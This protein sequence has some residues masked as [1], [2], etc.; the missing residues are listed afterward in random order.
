MD[1]PVTLSTLTDETLQ[2]L[3]P[4]PILMQH[5]SGGDSVVFHIVN[6][7]TSRDVG[8]RQYLYETTQLNCVTERTTGFFRS[9]GQPASA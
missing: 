1:T 4:L 8:P 9:V 3:S 7:P 6:L 5:H 2:W